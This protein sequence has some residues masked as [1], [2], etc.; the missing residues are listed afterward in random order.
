MAKDQ[1]FAGRLTV[2][3][4]ERQLSKSG[5]AREVGVSTTCVLNWE[6]GNTHPRPEALAKIAAVLGTTP[7][8][9]ERGEGKSGKSKESENITNAVT[10]KSNSVGALTMAEAKKSLALTFGVAPEAIEITI[11]G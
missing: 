9:L 11:R 3:R 5:L 8:F 6:K 2:L 10:G 1:G 4:S 7:A